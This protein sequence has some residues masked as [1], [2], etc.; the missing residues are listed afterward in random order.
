M[1]VASV[2]YVGY[3]SRQTGAERATQRAARIERGTSC[4]VASRVVTHPRMKFSKRVLWLWRVRPSS[5][6]YWTPPGRFTL[7]VSWTPLL[8]SPHRA[9]SYYKLPYYTVNFFTTIE[10]INNSV[11]ISKTLPR[12]GIKWYC[13]SFT[14]KRVLFP[15]VPQTT[16]FTSPTKL[17]VG[18][19][20]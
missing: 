1:F 16:R 4:S 15:S 19:N 7:V 8:R 18:V 12:C 17:A 9:E 20:K 10:N 13:I 3:N 2:L 14:N 6:M 11:S 5:H